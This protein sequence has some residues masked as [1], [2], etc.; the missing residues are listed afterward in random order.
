MEPLQHQLDL[1]S[2]ATVRVADKA[3]IEKARKDL[4]ARIQRLEEGL[5]DKSLVDETADRIASFDIYDQ[6]SAA[7]WFEP[8]WMFGKDLEDAFDLVIANPPAI[9]TNTKAACRWE[10][11]IREAEVQNIQPNRRLVP[12]V[13]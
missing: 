13:L 4:Q 6:N 10:N 2:K 11:G 7:T 5:M 1:A 9:H 12:I 8:E 3:K